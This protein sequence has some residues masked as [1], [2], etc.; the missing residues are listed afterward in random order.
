MASSATCWNYAAGGRKTNAAAAKMRGL[1]LDAMLLPTSE[2][3]IR[4]GYNYN[5]AH[6]TEWTASD[7]LNALV[8]SSLVDTS[9]FFAPAMVT[10]RSTRTGHWGTVSTAFSR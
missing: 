6:Y 1:E 8:R 7:P 4:A 9:R 5:D 2:W 3:E 10:T